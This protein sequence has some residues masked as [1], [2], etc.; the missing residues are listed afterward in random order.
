MWPLHLLFRPPKNNWLHTPGYKAKLDKSE[1][2]V[3][4]NQSNYKTSVPVIFR[5]S[6]KIKFGSFDNSS[7]N[8]VPSPT[9][10]IF[11]YKLLLTHFPV[12]DDC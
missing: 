1:D 12:K 10:V 2:V 6:N 5:G 8:L 9:L 11:W 7:A 4:L 3:V